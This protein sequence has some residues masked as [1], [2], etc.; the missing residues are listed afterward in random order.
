MAPIYDTVGV[1]WVN[2]AKIICPQYERVCH[3]II[4]YSPIIHIA[5][6][7]FCVVFFLFSIRV[8]ASA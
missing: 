8:I 7:Y 5:F 4:I 3:T 2:V 1:L 6:S